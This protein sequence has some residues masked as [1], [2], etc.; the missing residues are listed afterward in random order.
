VIVVLARY[1][2]FFIAFVVAADITRGEEFVPM[3]WNFIHPSSLES[4]E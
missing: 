1:V 2:V 3:G 4:F